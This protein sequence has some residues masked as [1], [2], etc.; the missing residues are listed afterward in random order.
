MDRRDYEVLPEINEI[1]EEEDGRSRL[2]CW[3]AVIDCFQQCFDL[4]MYDQ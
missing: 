4:M 2:T 1:K 3:D